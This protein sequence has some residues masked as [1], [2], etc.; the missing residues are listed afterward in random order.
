MKASASSLGSCY[1]TTRGY[2]ILERDRRDPVARTVDE[3]LKGEVSKVECLWLQRGGGPSHNVP[4]NSVRT[5]HAQ[6][7]GRQAGYGATTDDRAPGHAYVFGSLGVK[8]RDKSQV[9]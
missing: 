6:G 7:E 2:A 1:L 4:G 9:R 3:N 5:R 8:M